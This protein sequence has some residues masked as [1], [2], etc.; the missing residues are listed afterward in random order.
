MADVAIA[1]GRAT[2]VLLVCSG[3]RYRALNRRFARVWTLHECRNR[4]E[5][6]SFGLAGA[7]ASMIHRRWW[8]I[9][10]DNARDSWSRRLWA[11]SRERR[12]FRSAQV[13]EVRVP[14]FPPCFEPTLRY[15]PY[16]VSLGCLTEVRRMGMLL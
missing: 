11:S 16:K 15:G 5:S 2:R 4:F 1:M 3:K 14:C 8:I 13:D 12:C 10:K 6:I 7:M 9:G